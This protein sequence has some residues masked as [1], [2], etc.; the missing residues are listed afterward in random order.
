[1]RTRGDGHHVCL[2]WE[3]AKGK[4]KMLSIHGDKGKGHKVVFFLGFTEMSIPKLENIFKPSEIIPE[5]LANVALTRSTQ[6]LFVGFNHSYPSRY[7]HK[8]NTRLKDF[9]YVSWETGREIS[10][11]IPEPYNSIIDQMENGHL[12]PF[13]SVPYKKEKVNT[14]SKSQLEVKDDLSKDFEQAKDFIDQ[15]WNRN[16]K[17]TFF[18]QEQKIKG[19]FK[20]DYCALLGKITEIYP[21]NL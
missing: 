9:A 1:M 14:G 4:T 3:E 7:L 8:I 13:W 18:G 17:E 15:N 6:Y 11:Q 12:L 5:S 20:E 21:L 2:D 10:D 16:V 19:D